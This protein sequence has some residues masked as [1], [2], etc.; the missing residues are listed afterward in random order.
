MKNKNK[1]LIFLL[2]PLIIIS[3]SILI[4]LINGKRY[5]IESEKDSI[6]KVLETFVKEDYYY[7]GGKNIFSTIGDENFKKYLIARND[8][9]K[10]HF[11][12]ANYKPFDLKYEFKYKKFKQSGKFIK[13]DVYVTEHA[14]FIDNKGKTEEASCGDEYVIYLSKI[15]DS[16]KVMSANTENGPDAVDDEFNVNEELGYESRITKENINKNLNKMINRLNEL[17]EEYSKPIQNK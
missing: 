13:V 15:N 8:T 16:W 9:K 10:A 3:F 12:S 1:L 6:K 17:K 7:S 2:I 5:D 14:S 4:Y 11:I